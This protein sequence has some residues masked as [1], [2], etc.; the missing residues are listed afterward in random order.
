MIELDKI[1]NED[2]LDGMKKIPDGSVDCIITSPP[3][4]VGLS[5]NEYNDSKEYSDYLA[6]MTNIFN[7]CYRVLAADGR[8]CINIGDGKNGSIP[9]HSDFIQ[10]CKSIG[11]N[12]MTIIVWNKNTTSRRTAWGSFMSASCPSFPRNFEYILVFSKNKKLLSKG[13]STISKDDF[14]K[15]SNGMWTFNTEK[16]SQV[17]HPAAF[18]IELPTR[19]LRMLTYKDAIVLDMFMGSG[20]TAIACIKE[21]RHFIGFEKDETYWKKSVERVKNE[22]RQLTLF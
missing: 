18:P 10:I 6:W 8:M 11:F 1:Y 16:L 21:K 14:I 9:T 5:Y 19:L 15:W 13:E 2:C 7:V 3:Y 12:V 4:N 22:Q 17:G 20:T